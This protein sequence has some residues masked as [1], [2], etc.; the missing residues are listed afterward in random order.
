ME[1]I[2]AMINAIPGRNLLVLN[3]AHHL[4]KA[5][6]DRLAHVNGK[7]PGFLGNTGRSYE[8]RENNA[9]QTFDWLITFF[10]PYEWSHDT[11]GEKLLDHVP[12]H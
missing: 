11:Q 7:Q 3:F 2:C 4:P 1:L 5:W 9:L 12:L 10:K 8:A 6:T